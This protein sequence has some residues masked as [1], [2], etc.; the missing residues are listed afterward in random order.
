MRLDFNYKKKTVRNT[1]TWRLNSTFLSNQHI[2]EEN[3]R[4]IKKFPGKKMTVKTQLKT[5]GM[6]QKQS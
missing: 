1:N 5:Y 6:Q 3:K 4:E 2:T